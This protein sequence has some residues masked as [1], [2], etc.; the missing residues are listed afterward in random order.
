MKI[1][2][3]NVP[4]EL[5][6]VHDL[7]DEEYEDFADY[8]DKGGEF[9]QSVRFFRYK[10]NVYDTEDCEPIFRDTIQEFKEWDG[11]FTW[12]FYSGVVFKYV[13]GTDL[14]EVIVGR[15]CT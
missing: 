3:N 9:H 5:I 12:T 6:C 11:I 8:V 15:Y 2:T 1:T 14:E 4:R 13:P 7:T 10:G